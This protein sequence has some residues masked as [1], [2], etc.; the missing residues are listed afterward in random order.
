MIAETKTIIDGQVYEPGQE[1][2]DLGSLD[3]V[4]TSEYNVR[5]YVGLSTDADKLPSYT[6]SGSSCLMVDTGELYVCHRGKWYLQ[7]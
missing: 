5:D 4:H 7:E 1:L 2:P 6:A 3:C